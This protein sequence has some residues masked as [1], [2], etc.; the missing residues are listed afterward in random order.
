MT[1]FKL[2]DFITVVDTTDPDLDGL[3]FRIDGIDVYFP[4]ASFWIIGVRDH[5]A[6]WVAERGTHIKLTGHYM[7]PLPKEEWYRYEQEVW[8]PNGKSISR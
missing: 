4:E 1:N 8:H 7:K 6:T 5:R 3:V 2:G